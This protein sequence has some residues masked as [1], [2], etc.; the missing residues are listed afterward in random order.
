MFW[1]FSPYVH[2]SVLALTNSIAEEQIGVSGQL[3]FSTLAAS[4]VEWSYV[5]CI[6]LCSCL[7]RCNPL[8]SCIYS[9]I[10][11]CAHWYIMS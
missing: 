6:N 11:G 3:F 9:S 1:G 5:E 7:L 10:E 8:F 2:A 4:F